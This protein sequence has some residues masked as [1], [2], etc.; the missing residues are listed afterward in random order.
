MPRLNLVVSRSLHDDLNLIA[1][2]A[3]VS[4]TVVIR[5]AIALCLVAVR[6][7][8]EGKHLGLVTD[9]SKLDVEIVGLV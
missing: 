6:A 2:E 1:K 7:K 5:Q 3:E 9:P 4:M 8:R